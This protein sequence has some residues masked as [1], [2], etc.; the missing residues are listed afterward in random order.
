MG[1]GEGLEVLI[2][3]CKNE[4]ISISRPVFQLVNRFEEGGCEVSLEST[5]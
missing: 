5:K 4:N 2:F 1:A 3:L